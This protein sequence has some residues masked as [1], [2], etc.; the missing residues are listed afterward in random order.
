MEANASSLIIVEQ[1]PVIT[2][3]LAAVKA[4]VGERTSRAAGLIC[5]EE[6]VKDVKRIRAD[7][8]RE[9][10]DFETARKRVKAEVL[11][12][13]EDFERMYKE[14]ISGAYKSA[15]RLLKGK[16]G[17]VENTLIAEKVEKLTAYYVEKCEEAEI[18][19]I[20]FEKLG[21]KITLSAKEKDLKNQIDAYLLGVESELKVIASMENADEIRVEYAKCL[22]LAGAITSVQERKAAIAALKEAIAEE[23]AKEAVEELEPVEPVEEATLD[24]E[25]GLPFPGGFPDP[26]E[27][28]ASAEAIF[29]APRKTWKIA[30]EVTE[31]E[32]RALMVF[33][34]QNKIAWTEG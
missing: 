27:P 24:D 15:D 19:F 6:T 20:P 1:I 31:D 13:Y 25:D 30:V 3:N 12:P 32:K 9:F 23:K 16:I 21:L 4:E 5:T 10:A 34:A 26:D 7:L 18:D 29:E 33:M 2:Q 14:C 28:V 8:N 11:K 17:D 22:D